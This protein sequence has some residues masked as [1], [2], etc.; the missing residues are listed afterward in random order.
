MFTNV[1]RIFKRRKELKPRVLSRSAPELMFTTSYSHASYMGYMYVV[2][3][4]AVF[5][6]VPIFLIVLLLM[7]LLL[8]CMRLYVKSVI[9]AT[10]ILYTF[11]HFLIRL[12]PTIHPHKRVCEP[13][14]C[15]TCLCTYVYIYI[16]TAIS[17]NTLLLLYSL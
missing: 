12:M 2:L 14:N 1:L 9:H 4:T 6:C 3:L 10:R 15:F 8:S 16:Y 7:M 17:N 13:F 5:S 11:I